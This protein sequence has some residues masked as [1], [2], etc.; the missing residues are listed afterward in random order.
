MHIVNIF[1]IIIIYISI[2]IIIYFDQILIYILI[3]VIDR[4]QNRGT[5]HFHL[6]HYYCYSNNMNI[7]YL[8]YIEYYLYYI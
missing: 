7:E 6:L 2:F 5:L 8:Y 4:E 1:M 3:I